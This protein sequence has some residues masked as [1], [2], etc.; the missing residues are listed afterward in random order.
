MFSFFVWLIA[1]LSTAGLLLNAEDDKFGR[2][3]DGYA[4]LCHDLA[5][6]TDV[7][8]ICLGVAFDEESFIGRIPE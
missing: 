6:F 7:R 2:F 8:R 1:K 4:D 5:G 3:D